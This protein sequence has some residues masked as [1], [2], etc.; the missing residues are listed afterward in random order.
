[1]PR[2]I[3]TVEDDPAIRR[4]VVDALTFSGYRVQ[5][6]GNA[7][8]GRKLALSQPFDLILLDIVLPDGSGLDLLADVRE[9]SPRQPVI[10]LTA[11]G[12][13]QDRVAGLKRGADD[14]IV[15][16]FSV[17]ELLA[18]VEAV[19][20]RAGPPATPQERIDLG[21]LGSVDL[22]TCELTKPR[23]GRAEL[24]PREVQ[25]IHYLA[26]HADRVVG[27]D[28][29]LQNVWGI[30]AR[31]VTTRTIDMHVAR[32]REKLGDDAASPE[33]LVTVRGRGYRW[34]VTGA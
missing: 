27:R 23:G 19:L 2:S 17:K 8:E 22:A 32:L 4:G 24:S 28:E 29:L 11:R 30:D 31:G 5:Q 1:M 10:L 26:Q 20:R 7:C 25:L 12:E 13:E 9:R 6:A 18:R 16:P 3:L 34:R 21:R 15:K 14:Y 33:V